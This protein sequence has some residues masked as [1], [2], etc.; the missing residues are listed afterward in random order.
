MKKQAI[1]YVNDGSTYTWAQVNERANQVSHWAIQQGFKQ[2][3]VVALLME[4]RPEFLFT[5]IGMAKI[6]V[7]C[8]LI[9]TY[10]TGKPLI[11]SLSVCGANKAIIGALHGDKINQIR[12]EIT[13][14]YTWFTMNGSVPNMIQIDSNL[15]TQ[16]TKNPAR[17]LRSN[18][19]SDSNLFFIY[20][21][22]TTGHPKASVIKHLRFYS[23]TMVFSGMY[24]VT[25]SDRVYCCLPL[26]HSA[27]GII[28]TGC[29][30]YT[31]CTFV[32]R[33]KFSA[34][35]FW[36]DISENNCTV[37]Q[38]IGELCRYLLAQP[39]TEYDTAHKVRLAIGNGMR[40]DVWGPFQERF[41]IERIGE[42]YGATEGNCN[43]AN[44]RG[45]QGAVGYVSPLYAALFP[46]KLVKFD[47][48]KEEPFRTKE[49]FCIP[50]Q[51]G[52]P[53]ELLGF[54]DTKDP[55][56]AFDGYTDKKAT[57]KKVLQD[58][59]TKGDS[60][61]RSGDL[62]RQDD[63][64]YYYFVDRIGDTFRWKGENVSTNEVAEVISAVPGVQE[65]NVYG[66][67]VPGHDGKAGM[68][69]MVVDRQFDYQQLYDATQA[70]LPAYAVPLFLR[71]QPK[72]EITSTFKHKKTDLK[73]EGF[74]PSLTTDKLYFRD[75]AQ[76]K[77]VPLD[78][79]LFKD[80][81]SGTRSR[82]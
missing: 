73:K 63:S 23:A 62:L 58:V 77:Y 53:G 76:G 48:E 71:I 42:F 47:V 19:N 68:A 29:A 36:K 11:H 61:F 4:N 15:S 78:S 14:N 10:L 80:I 74:D 16:S 3:D 25:N 51:P 49:G 64:G 12:N 60:W 43:I 69:C 24:G 5:W 28:G 26:Y 44:T 38:Y 22:G 13:V 65:A 52:E 59:F 40:P 17:A 35:K 8:S 1:V 75:S 46:I 55:T 50:C 72:I 6:G 32:F 57:S 45:K 31:G 82:L 33:K 9:N 2:G 34:T 30:L 41:Q 79:V 70:Q 39:K 66:V 20:T 27:G 21:S 81:C 56:R 54:I 37:F 7:C 18:T 67:P